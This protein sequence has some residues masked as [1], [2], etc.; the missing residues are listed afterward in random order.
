VNDASVHSTYTWKVDGVIQSTTKNEIVISWA[1][2]GKFLITVQEHSANGCDG[3]IQSGYVY[4]NTT[5][6]GIRYPTVTATANVAMPLSARS[7]GLSY[8]YNWMP[9]AGLD[10]T[11][12]QNPV[13]KYDRTTEYLIKIMPLNGCTVVDSLT[14]FVA[15]SPSVKSS[16]YVPT[17]W[18]PNNDGHNDKLIPLIMNIRQLH[19]KIFNRWEQLLFETN[20]PGEG[21]DGRFNG[22]PQSPGVYVWFAD[23]EGWDGAHHKQNGTSVLIR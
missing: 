9:S 4:V 14:V 3:E 16:L 5:L 1:K 13:F 19:F 10:F 23:A 11:D 20:K 6:P 21:W 12:I 8:T 2:P 22:M 15:S 7:L 18:T 17:A